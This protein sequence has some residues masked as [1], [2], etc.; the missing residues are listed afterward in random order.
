LI[1]GELEIRCLLCVFEL[2]PKLQKRNE[3]SEGTISYIN[4]E[5]FCGAFTFL[6]IHNKINLLYQIWHIFEYL[7]HLAFYS[8]PQLSF[9]SKQDCQLDPLLSQ[10]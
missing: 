7:S 10:Y 9:F 5:G 4:H 1:Q 2:E 8:S 3:V 6:K